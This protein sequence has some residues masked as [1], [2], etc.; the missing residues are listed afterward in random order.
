MVRKHPAELLDAGPSQRAV[1]RTAAARAPLP[2]TISAGYANWAECDEKV[3]RAATNGVNVIVWFALSLLIDDGGRPY[4]SGGPNLTCVAGVAARLRARALPTHHF[5]S[6]GGWDAPHPNTTVSADQ[7]W[8]AWEAWDAAAVSAGLPGGFDGVDWD[9]EGDDALASASNTF[10]PALLH[11]IADFSSRAK[12]SGRYVSLAPAHSYLDHTTDAFSLSLTHPARCWHHDFHYSGRN[13]Y[14]AVLALAPPHTFDFVSLQLYE[15]WSL[16]NCRLHGPSP[17]ALADYLRDLIA[18]MDAGWPVG[19]EHEPS[20]GLANASVAVRATRL[21]LG[22]S[23][24]WAAESEADASGARKFLF[25]PP[26][27]LGAAWARLP[28]RPRG[29]MFWDL[30]DEGGG[31][32]PLYLASE[33]NRFLHVR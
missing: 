23:N 5:V 20:L 9:L 11:L 32:P 33:L 17:T 6:I 30:G 24:S 15:G 28:Q 18:G 12:A 1:H 21:V 26:A 13:V 29:L 2:S 4:I 22:I 27:R 25:V 10:T 8:A 3:E 14:A 19:F 16:A 7:W 31:T